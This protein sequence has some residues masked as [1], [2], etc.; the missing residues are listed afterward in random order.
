MADNKAKDL[1]QF[2]DPDLH[3]VYRKKPYT[4]KAASFKLGLFFHKVFEFGYKVAASEENGTELTEADEAEAMKLDDQEEG[5]LIVRALGNDLI[6]KLDADGVPFKII[7]L[8]S[9]TLLLDTVRDRETAIAYWN[10]GGKA[11]AP[12]KGQK[13]E[14]PTQKAAGTTTRKQ[15]YQSGTKTPSKAAA[16]SGPTSSSTGRK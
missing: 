2:Q 10:A 9:M 7:S 11:P 3:L 14:T 1:S 5:D 15:D 4:I 8:M 12:A 6:D 13:T 16:T